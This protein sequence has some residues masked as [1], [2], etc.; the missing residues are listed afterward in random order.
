MSHD[1]VVKLKT[2]GKLLIIEKVKI[3][4]MEIKNKL[5]YE[6]KGNFLYST[7]LAIKSLTILETESYNIQDILKHWKCDIP[8]RLYC[9][10]WYM[11]MVLFLKFSYTEVIPL[12]S[13]KQ[14]LTAN[15]L[16]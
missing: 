16:M 9:V 12:N 4:G 5:L 7:S 3:N 2:R 1:I 10:H 6:K 15:A 13:R 11:Y 8:N 14:C